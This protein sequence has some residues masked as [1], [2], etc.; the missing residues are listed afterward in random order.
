MT[1]DA[2]WTWTAAQ[3][4]R[5]VSSREVSCREITESC[6][7]RLEEVNGDLVA[8]VDIDAAGARAAADRAD[9]SVR[10]GEPLGVLHG[11]PVATK[12]N[13]DQ[14]GSPTTNGVRA[15]KDRVALNDNPAVGNLRDAGA[16]ILGRTNTPSFSWRWFTDNELHGRTLNP[17]NPKV[18]V[19]GSS[20][21]SAAAV[22]TGIVPIAHGSDLAGSIRYPAY[23]CGVLGLRPTQGRIP[24]F[25]AT[26]PG[27]RPPL[28]QLMGVQ[29]A[30]TRTVEDMRLALRAMARGSD[31]DPWSVPVPLE[32]DAT[33]PSRLAVVRSVP[34]TDVDASVTAEIDVSARRMEAAGYEPV[35]VVPPSFERVMD[36][37][38]A[39]LWE[40]GHGLLQRVAELGDPSMQ[41]VAKVM[42]E[43]AADIDGVRYLELFGLRTTI[44]R[45]WSAFLDDYPL[46]LMPVSWRRPF[47]VDYDQRGPD[48]VRE[49]ID[50]LA[51]AIAAN[52]CGLPALAVPTSIGPD[53]PCGVQF[54][55]G[56][57]REDRCLTAA[58]VL[59]RDHP[60]RALRR[61]RPA[62]DH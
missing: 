27:D 22:S 24:S 51:P 34:W 59:M 12:I 48:A 46:L 11:V 18:T 5:A 44:L 1:A 15:F 36:V 25:D 41:A 42:N 52:V 10:R 8:L 62:L 60:D 2:Y 14:R 9:R 40:A 37:F 4:T 38:R 35:E 39:A 21:G 57:F 7:A 49:V 47:P 16:I 3:I 19:G 50:A 54:V 29:G 61:G 6:L 20:G 28:S 32:L 26:A 17:W 55:A 23:A 53:G 43:V 13:V 45:E 31:L 33:P 30:M 56:R 58:E